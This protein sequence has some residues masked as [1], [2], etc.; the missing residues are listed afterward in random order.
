MEL[1][2]YYHNQ[3]LIVENYIPRKCQLPFENDFNL[4]GVRG[5]GKTSMILDYLVSI[6]SEASLYIDFNDPHLIFNPISIDKLQNYITKEHIDTLVLD[7][8]KDEYLDN[9]PKVEK[10]IVLSRTPL[11]HTQLTPIELFP[12]DYEEFLAFETTISHSSGLNHFLR[13]GTLPLLAH[14]QKNSIQIMKTFFYSAFNVNEQK[15]L[16]VLSQHHTKHLTINQ[17]YTFAKEKFK[18]SKDWLYKTMKSFQ[19]EKLVFFIEDNFQKSRKKML[20]FD[21][22][23][24]KYLTLGQPFITQFDTM[25]A[26]TLIKHNV[27]IQTLGIHGYITPNSE[28]IIP[29]P[30]E[31]EESLWVKSQSKFSLY[32]KYGIKKVH[33]ITV[34]NT[35]EYS[36]E[37]LYFEALPFDEW[38]VLHNESPYEVT[39]IMD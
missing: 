16:L 31:S 2:E 24:T 11:S 20:L 5:A 29:A 18:V 23:F 6:E 4:Y 7:H 25:I 27:Q 8:Y 9:L 39:T 22:A 32:K 3:Q 28:L 21:F 17:I 13:S 1:L 10:L 19:E 37:K 30:F 26:L 14:S 33:I 35:Y 38:S 34:A 36:I 15:L 12:L